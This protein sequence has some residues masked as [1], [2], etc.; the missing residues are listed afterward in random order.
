MNLV[1]GMLMGTGIGTAIGTALSVAGTAVTDQ[2][3]GVK[4]TTK[5]AIGIVAEN[6]GF[7]ALGGLMKAGKYAYDLKRATSN[8]MGEGLAKD[9]EVGIAKKGETITGKTGITK[10]NK[11]GI[12]DG[13]AR[14]DT[15]NPVDS[16][17]AR[18]SIGH[19]PVAYPADLAKELGIS[20]KTLSREDQLRME[21]L[22]YQHLLMEKEGMSEED[23]YAQSQDWVT[24]VSHGERQI[25]IN[26]RTQYKG[27]KKGIVKGFLGSTGETYKL[28][29]E[30][31]VKSGSRMYTSFKDETT[32]IAAK[33]DRKGNLI[34]AA[35][36]IGSVGKGGIDMDVIEE[37]NEL[38]ADEIK[39]GTMFPI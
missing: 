11:F 13:R 9:A 29:E 14:F 8:P 19:A 27:Y 5:A 36:S 16:V 26:G 39:A 32:R 22:H 4:F 12:D 20:S 7:T 6:M 25:K 37:Y 17:D 10:S 33:F 35:K 18:D 1:G 2:G 23:A 34:R 24:T 3:K 31:Y 28:T 15:S 30:G 38:F 21:A